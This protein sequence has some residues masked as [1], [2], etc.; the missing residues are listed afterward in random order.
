HL[1]YRT[2][3]PPHYA[4]RRPLSRPSCFLFLLIPAHSCSFLLIPAHSCSF[5]LIPA[6]SCSFLLIPGTSP[7]KL[8]TKILWP[9]RGLES[10]NNFADNVRKKHQPLCR[11]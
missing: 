5:L 8:S 11:P 10:P 4:K 7:P 9:I 6:H 1:S 2:W 3:A